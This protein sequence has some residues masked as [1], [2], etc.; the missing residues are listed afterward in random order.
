MVKYNY[1]KPDN[2]IKDNNKKEKIQKKCE[3][4]Q[5]KYISNELN[6]FAF[7]SIHILIIISVFLDYLK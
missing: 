7:N 1:V 3:I 2:F 5:I 6:S 4:T